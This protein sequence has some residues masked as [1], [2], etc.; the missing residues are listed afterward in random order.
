MTTTAT[1][2][3][4]AGLHDLLATSLRTDLKRYIDAEEPVPPAL[5]AQIIKFLKDNGIEA[6]EAA[7][8][9]LDDLTSTL[10]FPTDAEIQ[11][12]H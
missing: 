3:V 12:A 5:L 4:L 2:D 6:K 11:S 9:P 1:V 8:S 7:G 10:P